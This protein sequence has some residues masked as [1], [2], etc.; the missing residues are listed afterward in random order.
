MRCRPRRFTAVSAALLAGI[1]LSSVA[2]CR[3]GAGAPSGPPPPKI[4]LEV[5]LK[6]GGSWTTFNVQPSR[7]VGPEAT[8]EMKRGEISGFLNGAAVRLKAKADE[9]T[10][11]VGGRVALDVEER[12]GNVEISGVWNDDRV[13]FEVTAESLRGTITGLV[14]DRTG[15]R[16]LWHCQ[17]VLDKVESDGART[18]TSICSGMPQQT[19]LEFPSAVDKWLGRGETVVVLLALL[20]SAPQTSGDFFY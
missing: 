19:R 13:H 9:L 8:L 15:R 11:V 3:T 4:G 18:G 16:H 17:Y 6:R 2:G 5:G 10:G 12:D 7:V 14:E 20:S 1:W